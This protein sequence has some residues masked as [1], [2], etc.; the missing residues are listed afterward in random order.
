[1]KYKIEFDGLES[2]E[3]EVAF[4]SIDIL[5]VLKDLLAEIRSS[6]KHDSGKL[7]SGDPITLHMVRE[8]VLQSAKHHEIDNLL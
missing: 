1:M 2:F 5:A 8:F 4:K 7:K 6:D 3:H